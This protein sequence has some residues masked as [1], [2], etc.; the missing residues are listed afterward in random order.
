ML[1]ENNQYFCI[2]VSDFFNA[3]KKRSRWEN[4]DYFQYQFQLIKFVN[5]VVSSPYKT[6]PIK[7][8][9]FNIQLPLLS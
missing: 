4:L 7:I 1:E 3:E 9:E 8:Y 2:L 6:K 5:S